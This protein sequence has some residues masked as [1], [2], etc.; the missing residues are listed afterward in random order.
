VTQINDD[1]DRLRHSATR[2]LLERR[3]TVVVASVSCIYGLG[4]P[5]KFIEAAL[6]LQ[7]GEFPTTNGQIDDLG[8]DKKNDKKCGD[9]ANSGGT[10]G[11]GG[12]SGSGGRRRSVVVDF[13]A[14]LEALGYQLLADVKGV[15][16]VPRVAYTL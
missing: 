5:A 11:G 16:V 8:L 4:M 13:A 6:R 7:V 1:I 12:G 15:V 2:A 14:A 10:G 3:D 9:Q